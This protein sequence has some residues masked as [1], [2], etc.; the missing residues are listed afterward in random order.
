MTLLL[1]PGQPSQCPHSSQKGPCPSCSLGL[2]LL[3]EISFSQ[4]LAGNNYA[5]WASKVPGRWCT[6][7]RGARGCRKGETVFQRGLSPTGPFSQ[8]PVLPSLVNFSCKEPPDWE[9]AWTQVRPW[10][11]LNFYFATNL[12]T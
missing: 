1:P 3:S 6:G 5:R 10:I 8:V 12:V 4:H 7:L 9:K 11:F 2:R